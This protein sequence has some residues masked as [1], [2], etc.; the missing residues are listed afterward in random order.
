[1]SP[2]RPINPIA[3]ADGNASPTVI[4]DPGSLPRSPNKKPSTA[5]T[6][7]KEN[8]MMPTTDRTLRMIRLPMPGRLGAS[9]TLS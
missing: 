9:V 1:M 5:L 4:G 2:S 6:V 8:Q 3:I 7:K